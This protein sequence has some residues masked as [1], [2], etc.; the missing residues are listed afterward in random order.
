MI[1]KEMRNIVLIAILICTFAAAGRAQEHHGNGPDNILQ[2][3]PYAAVFTL[4]A[5]GVDN[6]HTWPQLTANAVTSL[7]VSAGVTYALKCSINE[8]RPDRSDR[9]SFPS[10]HSAVAFSGATVL[11]HE[12]GHVSPWLSVGGYAVATLTAVDR[13]RRDRHHWHDVAAGAGIGIL[14]TELSY[15][16]VDRFL[17]KLF[18]GSDISMSVTGNGVDVAITIK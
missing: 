4:K 3:T 17:T 12:F 18:P 13:V 10:G 14:S 9:R 7:A 1:I 15:F 6:S 11:H 2:Y 5:C 16:L 8:W